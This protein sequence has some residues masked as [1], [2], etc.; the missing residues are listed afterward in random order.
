MLSLRA[1]AKCATSQLSGKTNS[2]LPQISACR[3]FYTEN[4]D[5]IVNSKTPSVIWNSDALHG[6]T[7]DQIEFRQ[8]VRA[9]VEKELP[10]ELVKKV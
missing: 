5:D 10:E 1:I 6:L 9:F 7:K 3:S 2:V 4:I 8:S